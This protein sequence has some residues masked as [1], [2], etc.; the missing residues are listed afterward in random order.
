MVMHDPL[1]VAVAVDPGLVEWEWLR[2]RIG[3]GGETRRAPGTPTCRMARRVDHARFR[4]F[5]VQ[6]LGA[7]PS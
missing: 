7:A 3:P 4:S 5:L 6:R 1:A 2:L